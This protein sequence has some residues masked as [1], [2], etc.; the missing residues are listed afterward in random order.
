ME[1]N[2]QKANAKSTASEDIQEKSRTKDKIATF[3]HSFRIDFYDEGE[4]GLRGKI[5]HL[6]TKQKKAFNGYGAEIISSFIQRSIDKQKPAEEQPKT[7]KQLKIETAESPA[8]KKTSKKVTQLQLKTF[9]IVSIAGNK[10][11]STKVIDH[12]YPYVAQLE[13]AN[14]RPVEAGKV[15][16]YAKSIHGDH[17]HPYIIGQSPL[18]GA[19]TSLEKISVSLNP[20]LLSP[21]TYRITASLDLLYDQTGN[22]FKTDFPRK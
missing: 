21:G 14:A 12:D 5:E 13:L 6:L 22:A 20:A 8:S 9:D 1:K 19:D 3:K 10:K 17:V 11:K 2:T 7:E 15:M 16:I 4:E 18:R